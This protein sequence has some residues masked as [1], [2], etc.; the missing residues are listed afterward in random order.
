MNV[1]LL[2]LQIPKTKFDIYI[3]FGKDEWKQALKNSF[4]R[5]EIEKPKKGELMEA[6]LDSGLSVL[7]QVIELINQDAIQAE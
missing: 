5:F 3:N 1:V 4:E 2:I 6:Y 7:H